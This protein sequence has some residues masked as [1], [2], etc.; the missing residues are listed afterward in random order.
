MSYRRISVVLVGCLVLMLTGCGETLYSMTEQEEDAIVYYSAKMVSKYN[1]CQT[2]GICNARV[3]DGEL[4]DYDENDTPSDPTLDDAVEK[5]AQVVFD[6]ADGNVEGLLENTDEPAVHE[7]LSLSDTIGVSGI[8]FV[9]NGFAVSEEYKASSSYIL[10][11]SVGKKYLVLNVT[12]TNKTSDSI[13]LDTTG[14]YSFKLIV[15]GGATATSLQN[16]FLPNDLTGFKGSIKKD[17]SHDFVLL[18]QFPD[19]DVE[20]ITNVDLEV[21]SGGS[22]RSTAL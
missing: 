13:D 2:N 22:T 9:L 16:T 6:A 18:F 8:D 20:N 15:N 1:K 7:G 4:G 10:T 21:T 14:D 5:L 12:G 17:E 19:K 3:K 11:K